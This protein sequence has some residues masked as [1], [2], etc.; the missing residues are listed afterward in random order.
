M[1]DGG[2]RGQGWPLGSISFHD[3]AIPRTVFIFEIRR[4]AGIVFRDRQRSQSGDR[5]EGRFYPRPCGPRLSYRWRD[6]QTYG[7]T[8][9]A[10]RGDRARG[11]PS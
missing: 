3:P 11:S 8:G 4:D 2:N 5:R 10:D 1:A 9:A 6:R 7:V